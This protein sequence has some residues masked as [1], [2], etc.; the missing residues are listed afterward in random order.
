MS[1]FIYRKANLLAPDTR[2]LLGSVLVAVPKSA[3]EEL[4]AR[5]DCKHVEE[6]ALFG[7]LINDSDLEIINR[8]VISP[9]GQHVTEFEGFPMSETGDLPNPQATSPD[10]KR[11]WR[12]RS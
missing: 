6:D 2:A 12:L 10:G 3:I 9:F 7:E 4:K 1:E 11:F 5:P 8:L